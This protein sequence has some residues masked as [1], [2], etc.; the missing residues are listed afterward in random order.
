MSETIITKTCSKCKI[1]KPLTEFHKDIRGI[2]GCHSWCKQCK[3]N[4]DRIYHQ[5][6]KGHQIRNDSHNKYITTDKGKT[7]ICKAYK[8]Y[9]NSAKGRSRQ[10]RAELLYTKRYPNKRSARNAV[11][12]AIK[13]DM[14]PAVHT[15]ICPCG[16]SAQEYHHHLGYEPEHW[17]DV[18]PIC[19]PCHKKLG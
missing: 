16:N 5:T 14:I 6:D 1:I 13:K 2:Y 7:A 8:R 15:L 19:I 9:N 4:H 10:K 17:L 12:N 11:N 18:I 3:A